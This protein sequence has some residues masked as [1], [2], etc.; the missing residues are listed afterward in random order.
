MIDTVTARHEGTEI[1]R[2]LLDQFDTRDAGTIL[3]ISMGTI[4]INLPT[5]RD[6]NEYKEVMIDVIR[7]FAWQERV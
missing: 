1:A 6:F 7:H 3:S 4:L 5:Q 2:Q